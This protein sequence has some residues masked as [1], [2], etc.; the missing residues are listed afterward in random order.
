MPSNEENKVIIQ[1]TS[2][3]DQYWETFEVLYPYVCSL[4]EGIPVKL[5]TDMR[6][7]AK[8]CC[9]LVGWEL[10]LRM[11]KKK[12]TI[13][14]SIKYTED[15]VSIVEILTHSG[16]DTF[17]VPDTSILTDEAGSRLRITSYR[18]P[19]GYHKV[20]LPKVGEN[21]SEYVLLPDTEIREEAFDD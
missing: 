20:F 10:A 8:L 2:A 12:R 15:G 13:K 16:F 19:D 5:D 17:V 1:S 4:S 3:L 9:Q 6:E 21:R 14:C 7:V 18:T 11:L